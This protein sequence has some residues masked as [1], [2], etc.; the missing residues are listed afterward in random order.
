M[1]EGEIAQD[2][3]QRSPGLMGF[4]MGGESN[5]ALGGRRQL[6]REM[7]F[8]FREPARASVGLHREIEVSLG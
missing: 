4:S 1:E 2:R 8:A 5:H 7:S 6:N 3:G